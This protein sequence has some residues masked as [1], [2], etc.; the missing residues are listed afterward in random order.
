MTALNASCSACAPHT[1]MVSVTGAS[2]RAAP[3]GTAASA[4]AATPPRSTWRRESGWRAILFSIVDPP[5][6]RR[7]P[8]CVFD[9]RIDVGVEHVHQQ[10]DGDVDDENEQDAPLDERIVA[11]PDGL[12]QEPPESRISEHGFGDDGAADEARQHQPD[13]GDERQQRVAQ[14]VA[15]D[16]I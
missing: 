5:D 8:L 15:A 14:Y 6:R 13:H 11:R 10:I 1:A 12:N 16:D 2:A 7:L 4:V 9:A 3:R